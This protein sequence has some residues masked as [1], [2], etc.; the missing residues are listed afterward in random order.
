MKVAVTESSRRVETVDKSP[1]L[2]IRRT[3]LYYVLQRD[4][5]MNV[6]LR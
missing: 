2:R 4:G 3:P 1:A 5:G 6:S